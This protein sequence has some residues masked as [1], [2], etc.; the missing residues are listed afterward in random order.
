LADGRRVPEVEMNHHPRATL[1][2]A[3]ASTA[4]ESVR[5]ASRVLLLAIA[6]G[7][8]ETALV[9]YGAVTGEGSS[10]GVVPGVTARLVI[11]AVMTWVIARMTHGRPWARWVL[12]VAL[13]LLGTASL[14]IGPVE[15]LAADHALSDAFR[16]LAVRNWLFGISRT[17]HVLAVW[18]GVVLMFVPS[19]N[20]YFARPR[21]SMAS[22]PR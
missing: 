5:W 16:G 2:R 8:F 6:A 7:V 15:W 17:V 14:L 13:G 19:A 20:R 18:T 12:T 1:H 22:R 9:I 10:D 21:S 4:P 11:F 3:L